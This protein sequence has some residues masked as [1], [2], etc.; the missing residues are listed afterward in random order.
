MRKKNAKKQAKN[1]LHGPGPKRHKRDQQA[2][3]ANVVQGFF[4][5]AQAGYGFVRTHRPG[6]PIWWARPK[7]AIGWRLA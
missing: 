6:W 2:E 1:E 7:P 3:R 5:A 4:M